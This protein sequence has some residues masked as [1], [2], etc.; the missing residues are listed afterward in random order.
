MASF[1][2]NEG[3]STT[4]SH[5]NPSLSKDKKVT[6]NMTTEDLSLTMSIGE[7]LVDDETG[8][9]SPGVPSHNVSFEVGQYVILDAN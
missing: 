3:E 4:W 9:Y 1:T 6:R 7:G 5:R 8:S 2:G